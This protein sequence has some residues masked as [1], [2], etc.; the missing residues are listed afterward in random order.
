[1]LKK[2]RIG[3]REDIMH[4]AGTIFVIKWAIQLKAPPTASLTRFVSLIS[5]TSQNLSSEKRSELHKEEK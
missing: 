4:K 2:V 1:M 5:Y 3:F